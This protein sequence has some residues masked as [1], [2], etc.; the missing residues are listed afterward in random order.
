[1]QKLLISGHSYHYVLHQLR[2]LTLKIVRKYRLECRQV[3]GPQ[4]GATD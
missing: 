1:M 4:V 3:N 2:P